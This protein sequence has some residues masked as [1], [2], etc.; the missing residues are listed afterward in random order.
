VQL[1][2]L[3]SHVV[4]AKE[5]SRTRRLGALLASLRD[6]HFRVPHG[7]TTRAVRLEQAGDYRRAALWR[8]KVTSDV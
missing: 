6:R 4:D 8:L 1:E 5:T 7:E 2:P 3:P